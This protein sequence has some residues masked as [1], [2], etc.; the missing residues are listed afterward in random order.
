MNNKTISLLLA[1]VAI[2]FASCAKDNANEDDGQSAGTG[3]V[4]LRVMTRG[5]SSGST[6]M[7]VASPVNI[8]VFD[9]TGKCAAYRQ[10]ESEASA[11][12]FKLEAGKYTIYAVAGADGA[13]YN[14]PTV[15]NATT[16]TAFTLKSGKKHGDIM[17]A[18]GN[19]T[20]TK[21]EETTVTLQM[22]RKVWM[23]R[24]ISITDV[25]EDVTSISATI[26]PLY[27]TIDMK[28]NYYGENGLQTVELSQD[29]TTAT[30]WQSNCELFL[31]ESVGN[32][33]VIFSF[34]T[35]DG[36]TKTF[37][38]NSDKSLEAN[39][40]VSISVAYQKLAEPTL[41]CQING[42]EWSGE[43][44]WSFTVDEGNLQE[45]SG[46]SGDKG[47][48]DKTGTD[49]NAPSVGSLYQGCYVLQS[50]KDGE[51]T[52]VVL[53]SPNQAS[54]L[55]YTSTDQT[56]VKTAVDNAIAT[57]G[58]EGITGW[59]LPNKAE[60]TLITEQYKDIFNHFNDFYYRYRYYYEDTDGTIKCHYISAAYDGTLKS[61]EENLY[62]RPVATIYYSK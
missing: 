46:D 10:V 49:E 51:K 4:V 18:S 37:T 34:K 38:Y 40:K 43:D 53:L 6:A 30:T 13:S 32:P 26:K 12:D 36:K 55:V 33:S 11:A 8:Y 16:E 28:G 54:G 19:A 1:F 3:N 23:L 21:G 60:M 22:K 5:S 20:L 41:K 52:K 58:V 61:G 15:D 27:E 14:L 17:C 59:R 25:P 56:S 2:L 57:T 35:S 24:T 29:V 7:T 9:T 44:T 62:V 47:G 39:Y 48:D 45:D 50:E 42:V 31:M